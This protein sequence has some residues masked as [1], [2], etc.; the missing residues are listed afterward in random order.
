VQLKT[1]PPVLG[2]EQPAD[3]D[4]G[5][6]IADPKAITPGLPDQDGVAA[7]QG[8]QG[9]LPP[10]AAYTLPPFPVFAVFGQGIPARAA[11]GIDTKVGRFLLPQI[12]ETK[13]QYPVF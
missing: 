6:G 13:G 4:R 1:G 12:I 8:R 7:E 9:G 3:D 10:K 5:T 2:P 11:M